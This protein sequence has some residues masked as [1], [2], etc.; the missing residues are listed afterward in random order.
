ML[1]AFFSKS[2]DGALKLLLVTGFCGGFTTFSAFSHETLQL[3]RTGQT[4]PALLYVGASV[5]LGVIAVAIG[6]W[7]VD[8][9]VLKA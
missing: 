3:M 2:D 6:Y 4:A 9:T 7:L 8:N 1:M 5:V